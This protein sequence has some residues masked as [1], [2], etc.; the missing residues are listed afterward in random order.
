LKKLPYLSFLGLINAT[1]VGGMP[2][3]SEEALWSRCSEQE[4]NIQPRV[5]E[6]GTEVIC[7]PASDSENA[8]EGKRM[9]KRPFKCGIAIG[10]KEE[11]VVGCIEELD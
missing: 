11:W 2:L 7:S 5:S 4:L 6:M 10:R 8:A 3:N 9:D 1:T